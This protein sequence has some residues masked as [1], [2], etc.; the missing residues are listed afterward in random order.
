[1]IIY[2]GDCGTF[3]SDV[4]NLLIADL[5]SRSFEKTFNRKVPEQEK[6]S[7]EN[8]L[9]YME[10]VVR[11]SK[12]PDDCGVMVEYNL[13]NTSRR[14]DFIITGEDEIQQ[15]N[16]LLIEL[17]QW[18]QA[19][20]TDMDG[21]VVTRFSQGSAPVSHPSYQASGYKQFL[22]EFNEG[23]RNEN[24]RTH[25]C[26]FLHNYLEKKP[27]PL[28]D[29]RYDS[30]VSDSP[31]FFRHDHHLL[32]ECIARHVGKGKGLDILYAVEHGRIRPSRKLIDAVGRL[33]TGNEYFTLIDE[34][35]VLFEQ[36]KRRACQDAKEV[37]IIT[38]GPGTGKSVLAFNLLYKL[39]CEGKNVVLSAPNA[40]FRE[41]M[42]HKLK[43]AGLKKRSSTL[44]ETFVLDT[45]IT[46]SAGFLKVKENAYDVIVVDEA[47]RLKDGSA[48]AYYGKSQVEDIIRAGKQTIFFTD[49]FQMVRPEDIGNALTITA[50]AR[51]LGAEVHHHELAV[52][53][54]CSGMNGFINWLDHTLQIRDT[55]NFDGWDEHAYDVVLCDSPHDVYKRIVRHT[56]DGESA[57]LL[58]GYAWKWSS[59]KEGNKHAGVRDV[60]IEEHDFALPWN[61]R[62]SRST[63][64]IDESGIHQ[65]GCIHTSQGLEFEYVGVMIGN[66]LRYDPKS[67]ELFASWKD[68]KDVSGKKTLKEDPKRL[69]SLIKNIYKTLMTRAMKGCY[70]YCRDKP[71]AEYFQSCLGKER[72]GT[73]YAPKEFHDDWAAEPPGALTD[74]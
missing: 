40:A 45:I 62:S 64:A 7:W 18:E 41:V 35:K 15:R 56:E 11:N 21:I 70:V 43:Q 24:I 69:V 37:T 6:R 26:A 52:Q 39:L 10:R 23:I 16:L 58:A 32:S 48:Y 17:K 50:A 20:S 59:E 44:N 13:P 55:G 12:V 2:S 68:Y 14:I 4:D 25:S 53:F 66:D 72:I 57:R 28:K 54:R 74:Q 61:S 9:S 22:N 47:H 36:V 34:Q 19:E 38:G 73:A 46:G 33:F 63:W 49:D 27:E 51:F 67:K 71:L 65:V 3:K 42:K 60:N 1:M 5:I 31:I 30:Y 8:S 29:D